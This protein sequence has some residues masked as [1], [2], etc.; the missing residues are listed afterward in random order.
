M[1]SYSYYHC[2][3]EW[4]FARLKKQ[5]ATYAA[6]VYSLALHLARK[7]GVFHASIPR[8]AEYFEADERSIRKAIR[9][10]LALGFFEKISANPG[11]T[12]RYRPVPHKEWA[13][14]HPGCCTEKCPT[15]WDNEAKDT[16]G[17]E[18][19]AISGGKYNTHANFLKAMRKTGHADAAIREHFR[20]FVDIDRLDSRNS[21]I[22][23]VSGRFI[24][25]LRTQPISTNTPSHLM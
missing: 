25:Y 12:V 11:D 8:L 17:M 7:T 9:Q 3:S 24:K 19:H 15:P 22:H 13:A 5:G 10:L 1:E 20:A 16:L 21:R 18:L 6:I 4:H 2:S 14:K 23:G